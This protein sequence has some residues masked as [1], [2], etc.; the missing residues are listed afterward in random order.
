[1]HGDCERLGEGGLSDAET[2]RHGEDRAS[3]HTNEGGRD[4]RGAEVDSPR[5]RPGG[6]TCAASHVDTPS[7]SRS[8]RS[9][10]PRRPCPTGGRR[11]Q[12]RDPAPSPRTHG[13]ARR[14]AR[15]STHLLSTIRRTCASRCR[16]SRCATP[17]AGRGLGPAPVGR[18]LRSGC[19][20]ARDRRPPSSS[21]LGVT[22]LGRLSLVGH[23]AGLLGRI[24][25]GVGAHGHRT[26]FLTTASSLPFLV[27]FAHPT[28]R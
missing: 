19:H 2:R 14:R 12:P 26:L 28:Y 27:I 16:R 25:G 7:S 10:R 3:A 21:R 23:I 13:R 8:I 6:G 18:F 24:L 20:A 1:M 4:R 15:A 9:V 11:H 5:T 17:R 22:V